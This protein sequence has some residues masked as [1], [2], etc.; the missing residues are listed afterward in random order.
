MD[1]DSS[2]T[3][4]IELADRLLNETIA[5]LGFDVAKVREEIANR[6]VQSFVVS[7]VFSLTKRPVENDYLAGALTVWELYQNCPTS[8][9][10]YAELYKKHLRL[11]VYQFMVENADVLEKE[12]DLSK[13]FNNGYFA[14]GTLIETYLAKLSYD[15]MPQEIPQMALLRIAVGKFCKVRK[16]LNGYI[17]NPVANVLKAY[18]RYSNREVTPSSPTFFNEGFTEGAPI[19]CMIYTM[20]DSLDDIYYVLYEA[21]MASKNSAGLGIDFTNLRHSAIGRKGISQGI[22]PLLK[23]WDD[24]I[25]Y[26]NQGGSRNGAGT[27]SL[28]CFHYDIPEFVRLLDKTNEDASRV[29]RLN[30]SIMVSDMFMKRVFYE[31]GDWHLFCP[32][33][34][35]EL[36]MLHG[37][38]F[39]EKYLEMEGH[40]ERWTRYQKYQS[41]KKLR[42]AGET[43]MEATF[44]QLESDFTGKPTPRRM[45]SRKVNAKSL[46]ESICDMQVKSGGPYIVYSCSVN[47]KNSMMNVGPVRSSNLCQE[48]MIPAV[49]REQTGSCNLAA[50]SLPAFATKGNF[51]FL[52]FGEVTRD[53]IVGL[54]QV[55]DT[56]VNV[57]EKV[58]KSNDLSRP[59]GLGVS[60]LAD[61]LHQMDLPIVDPD[62]LPSTDGQVDYSEKGL[63]LRTLNP[64]VDD[65]N[66]KIWS[67]MYYNALL[68]SM[69]EAKRYGPCP[70]FKGSPASEGRLQFHFWQEEAKETGRNYPFKLYP[71][72]PKEWGQEGGNWDWLIEQI[73]IHGLRNLLLLSVQPTASSAQMIGNC[74][75]VELHMANIYTR[76]VLSGDYPVVNRHMV[77]DL[78]AIGA[79]NKEVYNNIV[80]HDGSVLHIP[81]STV[82]PE[83]VERLRFIKEKYLTMWEVPQKIM[84]KLAAQR[85]ICVCQSQSMNLYI[86]FPTKERL[87][88]IHK[89]TWEM[90]LKTGMYYL[91]T[92]ASMEPLKI[93]KE[94]KTISVKKGQMVD[95]ITAAAKGNKMKGIKDT[96]LVEH[97]D[98]ELLNLIE[99]AQQIKAKE[100]T[101]LRESHDRIIDEALISASRPSDVLMC[102]M[103]PG[104]VTCT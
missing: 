26:V 98:P 77:R 79:W 100:E 7:L 32:K 19:S 88:A 63:L 20:D 23:I 4:N 42:K 59:L 9:R 61:M 91:R 33:Q 44:K 28:R 102:E 18:Q 68:S 67:C 16:S 43:A 30:L 73:K 84:V 90:G 11:D 35:K 58:K 34:A 37:K 60:G 96:T 70:M 48:T 52:R 87:M 49:P 25:K 80:D 51:D 29:S 74:E 36:V 15:E 53:S 104:C 85:Q 83:N 8:V 3:P 93:G 14:V 65:L 38:A 1:S 76:K 54:N 12:V 81:E 13:D 89:Y 6:G 45:D 5:R 41:L 72:E 50:V 17:D 21:Q 22:I 47:R 2:F 71:A 27:A 57:S 62:N 55:I 24:S 82:T 94:A 75:S 64:V 39:E 10:E 103:K 40:A 97:Y 46:M 86:A 69:E 99:M 78:E 101:E 92:K 66:W 56:A 95:E 31:N